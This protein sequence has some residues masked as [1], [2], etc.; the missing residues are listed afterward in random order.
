MMDD[1][2]IDDAAVDDAI[3]AA[4]MA[5]AVEAVADAIASMDGVESRPLDANGEPY[6][7]GDFFRHEKVVDSKVFEV[8]GL[9]VDRIFYQGD[10]PVTYAWS[11]KTVHVREQ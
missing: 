2:I 5:E 9:G 3:D 8:I 6:Y 4:A 1:G 11:N 10:G 7:I